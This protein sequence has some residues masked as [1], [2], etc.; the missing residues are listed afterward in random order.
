M[1]REEGDEDSRVV[2]G[3]DM[4]MENAVRRGSFSVRCIFGCL[5]EQ[6]F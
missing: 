2:G 4:R 3:A 5:L 1:W 6:R